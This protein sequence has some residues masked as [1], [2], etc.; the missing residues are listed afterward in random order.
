MRLNGS[1]DLYQILHVYG[2]YFGL[3]TRRD[4]QANLWPDDRMPPYMTLLMFL[5]SE[6]F[7]CVIREQLSNEHVHQIIAGAILHTSKIMQPSDNW[8]AYRLYENG[9]G[10]A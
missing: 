5:C 10:R 3:P 4:F 9:P 6:A 7:C 1:I 2:S 8:G